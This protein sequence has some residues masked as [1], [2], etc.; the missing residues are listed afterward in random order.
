MAMKVI[1]LPAIHHDGNAVLVSGELGHILVDAGTSWYQSLQVERIRGQ[2]NDDSIDRIMLT[3]RRFPVSGGALHIAQAFGGVPIHIHSDGQSALETGDFFTTWASR[4]DSDMPQTPTVEVE[5]NEI[6][7]LGD[8]E[9]QAIS[10]PGHSPDGLGYH[11]PHL[12]TL[13][14]GTLLP[15][16]DRPTRWDLPGGS[17]LEII[18]SFQRMKRMNLKSIVPL[19]GPAIRGQKHVQD[20]LTRHLDF[21]LAS[22]DND[23]RPPNSWHRPAAT[24]LW[25]TPISPWPLEEQERT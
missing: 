16:A 1:R 17:L 20:V 4:F 11:I 18:E 24:A 19:Q 15:R 12:S 13:I 9:L 6:I 21:F 7:P 8:G 23:G 10:L 25:L 22:V 5:E 14:V 2:I 3:S